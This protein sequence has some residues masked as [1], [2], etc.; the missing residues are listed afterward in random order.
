MGIFDREDDEKEVTIKPGEKKSSSGNRKET[1]LESEVESKVVSKNTDSND[2][3][4]SV[5]SGSTVSNNDASSN[6]GNIGLE[7]VYR[8]NERIIELLEE[9][10]GNSNK[11]EEDDNGDYNGDIDGVL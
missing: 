8:Q 6:E 1:R 4:S 11:D 2:K 10:S 7:D 9:I 3:V 5:A